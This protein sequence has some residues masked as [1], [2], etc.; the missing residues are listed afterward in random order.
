MEVGLELRLARR[1]VVPSITDLG[2]GGWGGSKRDKNAFS[3]SIYHVGVSGCGPLQRYP[4][5]VHPDA[6]DTTGNPEM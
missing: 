6:I 5:W 4:S 3:E 1:L 2:R